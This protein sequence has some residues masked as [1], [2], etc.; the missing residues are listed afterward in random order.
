M[1]PG[2]S[3]FSET[4]LIGVGIAQ[5]HQSSEVCR[6]EFNGALGLRV[7]R[8]HITPPMQRLR[9]DTMRKGQPRDLRSLV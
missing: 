2:F 5:G 8:I 7:G 4:V 1:G 6:I 3:A 9:Q